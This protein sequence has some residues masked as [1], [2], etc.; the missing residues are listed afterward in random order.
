MQAVLAD[1]PLVADRV[2]I[3]TW[4]YEVNALLAHLPAGADRARLLEARAVV[5]AGL[6]RSEDPCPA[7]RGRGDD[8]PAEDARGAAVLYEA[9]GM[10]QQAAASCLVAAGV[11]AAR[12]NVKAS[13][14]MAVRALVGYASVPGYD[15]DPRTGADLAIRLARLCRQVNDHD[16]ALEFAEVAVA[17]SELVGDLARWSAAT[18]DVAEVLLRRADRI[19]PGGEGYRIRA[20]LVERAEHLARQLLDRGEPKT[21][22]AVHG[23]RLL[24]SA[25][26]ELGCAER[27][28]EVLESTS[29][30]DEL[31]TA[32][33]LASLHL[34]RGRCL[35]RLGRLEEALAELD[36][37]VPILTEG[38]DLTDEVSTLLL[39]G[40]VHEAMGDTAGA[41]ADARLLGHRLWERHQQQELAFMDQ[42]FSRAGVEGERR[43]LIAKTEVLARTAEQ[44]PLT[45]LDNRRGVER[46]LRALPAEDPVCLLL[47]D[48]DDFKLVNDRFGHAVGDEVL[49]QLGRLLVGAVREVDRVSRWGGE[50]FLVVLP[51]QAARFGSEAGERIRRTVADHPWTGI[52]AGL[53]ITVS[54]GV[55][56]GPSS[57]RTEALHRADEALYEAK[58]AGRNRVVVDGCSPPGP[59]AP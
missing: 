51:G 50:E 46:V 55:A 37:A 15:R 44:G 10:P 12:G 45:G 5:R 32:V 20:G 27:A 2:T 39:R 33:P 16:R 47:L 40:R 23:P 31:L 3:G 4:L 25:L 57:G 42:V 19:R 38:A 54:V 17:Q 41:L 52:R 30:A 49:R 14:E 48:V 11:H 18:H 6:L 24:A 34:V 36:A 7:G 35:Y 59:S 26:C 9:A 21:V 29:A 43:S 58:R 13:T 53:A 28:W 1:V 22:R 56:C 8:G